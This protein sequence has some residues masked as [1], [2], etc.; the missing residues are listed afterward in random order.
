M[1]Y[2]RII[3]AMTQN[4]NGTSHE[5]DVHKNRVYMLWNG[6]LDYHFPLMDFEYGVALQK[7]STGEGERPGSEFLVVKFIR[8]VESVVLAIK[9]KEPSEDT[10]SGKDRAKRELAE[11]IKE[12]FAETNFDTIYGIC[13]IDLGWTAYKMNKYG[14][15]ELETVFEWSSNIVSSLSHQRMVHLASLVDRMTGTS[16]LR[17]ET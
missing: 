5:T 3:N 17:T 2:P 12:L 15:G 14:S 9:L 6:I 8:E 10:G 16:R 4:L 7:L 13:G 11:Y 1:S